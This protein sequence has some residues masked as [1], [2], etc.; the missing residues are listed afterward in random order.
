MSLN[1]SRGRPLIELKDIHKKFPG[2]YALRGVSFDLYPGEVHAL[3]GENGAG[4]STIIKI[5][6]G[7][8]DFEG[9]YLLEGVDSGIKKPLDAIERGISIIYQELNLVQDLSIAEN[10]FF[11]RLLTA[12]GGR[13]LWKE[14]YAKTNEYLA[15]VGLRIPAKTK[16]R[17]LPVAQ[18][19]LVEIAKSLSLNARVIIMDEP[20]SALCPEEIESLFRLVAKLKAKGVGIVYVSHKLD[21]VFAI[22][23]RVTVL[24][25]GAWIGTEDVAAITKD[26]LISMMVGREL[27][28]LFPKTAPCIGEEVLRAE[29]LTTEK[30]TDVSFSVRKG[31][32]VGFAGL[33]GAGRTE[34][35]KALIGLDKKKGGKISLEGRILPPDSPSRASRAGLGLVPEDRKLEGIF[36]ELSVK[37]N[38][39]IVSLDEL[40]TRI[41]I[42]R[43]KE[44]SVVD[45][46]IRRL[47]IRTPSDDQLVAKLSGGNQ[48]KV[49]LARWLI[50][51]GVKV[52]IIDEPTRGIDVGAKAEIYK[53][54]DELAHQGLAIV[55]MSSEM[56]ELIGI[57]ER[58]YVMA[59]GRIVNE[60]AAAEATQEKI[61]AA[62]IDK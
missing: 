50:K 29:G 33:M 25:D 42:S 5:M 27:S 44:R 30:V 17:R 18:Q 1:S 61:F 34:L 23:D 56:P 6:A 22:A 36:P 2:V 20:T 40:R 4:K 26:R 49:I 45:E 39:S 43:S 16:V 57:C 51:K 35:A 54:V 15:E 60:M 28:S 21:E 37:H 32:I 10:I 48:Q 8:Y 13:V 11:G 31:E 58:I 62:C 9:R 7:V 46:V 24:R 38:I 41:G 12:A 59:G 47:G 3:M 52:L 55:I 53:I 14:V 19:Q